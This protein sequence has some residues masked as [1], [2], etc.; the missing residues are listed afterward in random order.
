MNQP[1]GRTVGNALE[2]REAIETLRGEGPVD[3]YEHCMAVGGH[4]LRLGRQDTSEDALSQAMAD[5]D[6]LIQNGA[7]LAKFRELVAAQG[8]DV[9]MVDDPSLLPQAR[10]KVDI[11]VE[12]NGFVVQ[13]SALQVARASLELGAGRARKGDPVD[14]AV[15]V[16]VHCNVGDRV[17]A[18]D[19][20]FTVHANDE[21]ALARATALLKDAPVYRSREQQPLPM[22]YDTIYGDK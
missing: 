22:F 21:E 15:G 9:S 11:P 10:I 12:E 7:G 2:V 19:T 8:G 14:P 3:L 6:E 17:R 13:I 1:L 18:G 4:M 5:L 16:E 20:M